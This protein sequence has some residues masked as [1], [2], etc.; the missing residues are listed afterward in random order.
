MT[1]L[2]LPLIAAVLNAVWNALVK[3]AT[4]RL[5]SLAWVAF[6]TTATGICM[7]T[8]VEMPAPAAWPALGLSAVLHYS[9]YGAMF[10]AYKVGDLS[11]VYPLARGVAPLAVAFGSAAV[12][13]EIP[14]L[15]GQI[16]I[17]VTCFGILLLA[18]G[19]LRGSALRPL[20]NAILLGLIISAYSVADGVGVRS[21]GDPLGYIA[22]LYV[23]DLPVV[24]VALHLRRHTIRRIISTS[25]KI[26]MTTGLASALGYALS[27][28]AA[29]YAPVAI[30]S[31]IRESS[32]IIAAVIGTVWLGERPWRIRIAAS[33][34]VGIGVATM[35]VARS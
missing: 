2:L 14:S 10:Q 28:Y 12:L 24:L 11:V 30:V 29:A 13:Q 5:V 23:F 8:A 20:A 33:V 32:V 26:G 35:M 22:L 17:G 31:A 15:M 34:L 18:F 7:L 27:I 9:Y 4:D 21:S 3:V 1:I 6:V 25:W 16:G 19:S